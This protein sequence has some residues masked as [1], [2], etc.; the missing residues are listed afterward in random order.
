MKNFL[1]F[2]FLQGISINTCEIQSESFIRFWFGVK[3]ISGLLAA[4]MEP[5][6]G[7]QARAAEDSPKDELFGFLSKNWN[8]HAYRRSGPP[9]RLLLPSVF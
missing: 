7:L 9:R 5:S 1:V 6:T 8:Q 3:I 2:A 4:S